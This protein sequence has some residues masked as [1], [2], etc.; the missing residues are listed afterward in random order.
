MFANYDVVI[1]GG[2]VIGCSISRWLSKYNLRILLIERSED[3]CSGTSKANSGII[4]GGYAAREGS[5]KCEMNLKGNPMFTKAQKELNFEFKRIGS[6]VEAIEESEIEVLEE[7]KRKG[8]IRNIPGEIIKDIKKI[9]DM[10]PNINKSVKAVYYCPVAGII[11]PFGLTIALAENAYNNG[12]NFLFSSP[13]TSIKKIKAGNDH[14][15]IK[16]GNQYISA[17]Y[18]INAA[19]VYADKIANMVGLNN[20]KISVRKGDYI[21]LDKDTFPLNHIIFPVPSEFSKGILVSP[22]IH[23]NTFI[24][25][26]SNPQDDKA[27]VATTTLGLN[28]IISGAKKLFPNISLRSAIT[29]FAGLR[30]ISNHDRDFIIESSEIDGFINVAGICSPGLSSSLAIAEKVVK[31]LID[32]VGVKL[33]EKS[34]WNP[35]RLPP[36]RLKDMNESSLS[37]A[38]KRNPQWGRIICRCETVTEAEIVEVIHRHGPLGAHSIDMIKKRLRPGMGRCQGAFCTPKIIKILSRELKIPVEQVPKNNPGSEYIVGRT[39]NI[40]STI[41]EGEV[42]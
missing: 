1:I 5:L 38:I 14:F 10:E 16:A 24:G 2:G 21:L 15:E 17:R 19:G 28:E 36:I 31:I 13:V 11:W 30:A 25:P 26:N 41:W 8:D 3:V 32:D 39:K 23:G 22:T 29:N 35:I 20:F 34:N 42:P 4:H 12:V 18:I 27:D 7:E 9:R 40:E 37:N 33:V 6:F